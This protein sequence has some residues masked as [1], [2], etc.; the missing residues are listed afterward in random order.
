QRHR[1]AEQ[2][3]ARGDGEVVP[4][5]PAVVPQ[6]GGDVAGRREE[7]LVDPAEVDV[8]LPPGEQ[9]E[10]EKGGAHQL[11]PPSSTR[12]ARSRRATTGASVRDRGRGRGTGTSAT[13]RPG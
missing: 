9:R 11:P 7:E 2:H 1:D 6:R 13:T 4:Q 8:E 10:R 5:Q 12:M 3:L